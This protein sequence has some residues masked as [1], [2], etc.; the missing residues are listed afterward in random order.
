MSLDSYRPAAGLPPLH[1][2][3]ARMGP[4]GGPPRADERPPGGF[5]MPTGL[6]PVHVIL[7]LLTVVTTTAAGCLF[8]GV[9]PLADPLALAA[10]L[11]YAATL[12]TILLVHEMGHYVVSRVHGVPA[13]PPY[14]IPAPPPI[15]FGTMG[16]VIRMHLPS[17]RRVL[18]DVGAAGPWAGL[19]IAV[20][21]VIV[22]LKFS[23]VK[24]LEPHL[25]GLIFGDSI[26]F[27]FLV[28]ATLGVSPEDATILLHPVA[29]AGWFGLLVTSF[30]LLPVGQLDGGHVAYAL[31]GRRH[32][33]LARFFIV[34][35]IALAF[36]GWM[37]WLL[38]AGL[39]VAVIGIYHPPTM[40]EDT[41][42]DSRRR[43]AGWLT[44]VV[45]VVTFMPV[46]LRV[47]MPT[48]GPHRLSEPSEPPIECRFF[49]AKP[50]A[51][52][53]AGESF[54]ITRTKEKGDGRSPFVG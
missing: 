16:A 4:W 20:P 26:L 50:D 7:F 2:T 25:G 37:G 19:L 24:P 14:F 46:P 23:E 43:A 29:V 30:N 10:G 52:A 35:V 33:W 34:G 9:D 41:P 13:T 45:F 21:A 39:L 51:G 38:W 31:L 5:G 54:E 40:D 28:R 47:E 17:N 3:A 44:A 8:A 32:R 1:R 18:F 36:Q 12:L 42:L 15:P 48:I 53:A 27:N 6:R 11:P 49:P 22:G